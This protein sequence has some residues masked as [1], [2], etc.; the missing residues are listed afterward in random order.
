MGWR[1]TLFAC[2]LAILLALQALSAPLAFAARASEGRGDGVAASLV[3]P[4]PW[5]AHNPD[6]GS[7]G[8]TDRGHHDCCVLCQSGVRD[9]SILVFALAAVGGDSLR[10]T[11]AA[12]TRTT[13]CRA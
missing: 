12:P 7:G 1:S 2:G 6:E 5:C 8:K 3:S 10:A 4:Q 9:A 11:T 13:P